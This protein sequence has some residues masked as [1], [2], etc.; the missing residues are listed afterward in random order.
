MISDVEYPD[1][2]MDRHE[3]IKTDSDSIYKNIR[4]ICIPR[5]VVMSWPYQFPSTDYVH[6]LEPSR[7]INHRLIQRFGHGRLAGECQF[8][9]R[10]GI[11]PVDPLDSLLFLAQ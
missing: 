10:A 5:L 8:L 7:P 2:D 11:W 3:L 1:L 6:R 9:R 4:T